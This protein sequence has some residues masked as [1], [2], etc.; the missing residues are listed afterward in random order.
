MNWY[1][2]VIEKSKWYVFTVFAV[3]FAWGAILLLSDHNAKVPTL[4]FLGLLILWCIVFVIASHFYR[5]QLEEQIQNLA[6]LLRLQE[7]LIKLYQ[8]PLYKEVQDRRD[9]VEK[10]IEY[11]KKKL[12][13]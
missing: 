11:C 12:L 1:T 9:E 4:L 6:H 13:K 3:I 7:T 8:A 5:K 10:E 2:F